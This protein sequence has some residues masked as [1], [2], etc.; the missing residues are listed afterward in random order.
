MALLVRHHVGSFY[1]IEGDHFE[2]RR[3]TSGKFS[4][5]VLTRVV[6]FTIET[7]ALTGTSLGEL[8]ANVHLTCCLACLAVIILVLYAACPVSQIEICNDPSS[9]SITSFTE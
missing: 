6:Q 4:S 5:F 8:H 1:Y 2:Q 3:N 9:E 7:N